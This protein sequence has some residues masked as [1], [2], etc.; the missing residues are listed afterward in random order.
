MSTTIDNRVVEMRFDNKHFENNVQ[1]SLSTIDKLKRS[2]NF[3]GA[4][5]GLENINSA[6][7][8]FDMSGMGS[9]VD[10]VKLKFS[11]LEVMAVTTLANITNSAVNAGK[12]IVSALTIDPI[13]TGFQE[14]ETQIGAVQTILA[15]TQ[16]KG[17]NL[18]DVNGAL[19]EL[20][21]YA[22]KTIYNFTEMTRNI[23]TF[24][25]AGVDLD[26][27]VSS[28][29]GI[30]NLAAVSGSTSQQASTAM[31]QLSQ[32]LA[33][34]KVQLM[35]WNSVVNAGMGGQVFQDALKRTAEH[36]GTNV[37]A[38]IEKYGSFRESLTQG[39]WLTAEVLTETLTQLSGAYS[40]ADLIAQGYTEKQAQEITEL[41]QTAVDAATKVKT[42]TQLWDTLKEAAQSGW[43]QTWEILIGDF[44]E[45]KSLWTTVSDTI[46]GLINKTS[47]SRNNLLEGAMTSNWDKLI[48]KVKDA[49]MSTEDF[50]KKVKNVAKSHDVDIDKMVEKYGSLEKVFRSGAVSSDILKEALGGTNEA[51]TTTTKEAVNHTV[52]A[53]ETLSGLAK[54][55]GT[56]VEAIAKL[57]NIKDVNLIRTGQVLKI[58]EAMTETKESTEG[59]VESIDELID[60]VTELGGRELL[61]ESFKN[62]FKTLGEV[63]KI[64][65]GTFRSIFPPTTSDQLYSMI[66]KFKELTDKFKL[67]EETSSKLR[68]TFKGLFAVLDILKKVVGGAL[69]VGFKVLAK[70]LGF[71]ADKALDVTSKIGAAA[72]R[73]RH[74]L[75]ENNRLVDGFEFTIAVFKKVAKVIK[76]VVKTFLEIPEVE[77]AIN[78]IKM[79]ISDMFSGVKDR[80]SGGVDLV[81]DFVT[82]LMTMDSISFDDVL[83]LFE[84]FKNRIIEYFSGI[85]VSSHVD[86]IKDSLGTFKDAALKYLGIAGEKFEWIKEKLAVFVD[87][88]KSKIPA[89][90][91]IGMGVGLIKGV[92]KLGKALETLASPLEGLSDLFDKVG[93][94]ISNFMKAKA[95][96]ERTEGIKNIAISI[97]IL[98]ASLTVLTM[99]DQGKLWSAVGALGVLTIAMGALAVVANKFGGLGDFGKSSLSI[100]ALTGSLFI[101]TKCIES[102]SE[103]DGGDALK[104]LGI[105]GA[106]TI[107]LAGVV[108]A[109]SKFAPKLSTGSL[110]FISLAAGIAIMVNALK[111]LDGMELDNAGQSILILLGIVGTLGLLAKACSG[112]KF[113]SLA[114]IVAMAIGLKL[115]IGVIEDIAELDVNGIKNNLESFIVIFGSLALLMVASK[116]AG[117]HAGS[118]GLGILAM[119]AAL[120]LIV[121]G[122]KGLSDIDKATLSRASNVLAKM[123]IVFAA[124]VSITKFAG[125]H[126]A[127]AGVTMLAMSSA[128]L[129]LTGAI[130]ILK[131]MDADGLDRALDAIGKI[132]LMFALLIASTKLAN[133]CVG[134]LVILTVAMGILSVAIAGLSQIE[135]D[136]LKNATTA[137]G[138]VIGM[139]ALLMGATKLISG[140]M[141]TLIVMTGAITILAGLIFLLSKLPIESTIGIAASLSMLILSLSGACAILTLI[142]PAGALSGVGALAIFIAGLGTIMAAIAGLNKL[143]PGMNEFLESGLPTIELLGKGLGSFF[144]GIVGGFAEGVTSS[145]PQ[146]ATDLSNFMTNLKPFIDG[147]KTVDASMMEGVN[148]IIDVI[149]GLTAANLIEGIASWIT[150]DSSVSTFASELPLLGEGLKAFSDNVIGIDTEAIKAAADATTTLSSMASAIP[151]EGGLLGFF[152]GENSMATFGAE[153]GLFGQGLKSFAT[154]VAGMDTEAVTAA[155]NAAMVLANMASAI[156]NEGGLV[157]WFAGEND[158]ATFGTQL[159]LFGEGLKGFAD[160][161]AGIDATSVTAAAT[162]AKDIAAMASTIPNEGG[163]LSWFAGENSMSMFATQLPLFGEGLKGFADKVAGIDTSSITSAV[164]AANSLVTM[165]DSIPNEGGLLALFAGDNDMTTFSSQ[166]PLFAEGIKGFA[167]K[168]AGIDTAAVNTAVTA[169]ADLTTMANNLPESGGLWSVFSADNDLS[170][171]SKELKKFGEG[172]S[173]FSEEVSGID[174]TAVGTSIA[175]VTRISNLATKIPEGGYEVLETF[176]EQLDGLGGDF[177]NFAADF[178]SIDVGTL[179]SAVSGFTGLV[180]VLSSVA[181]TD[182]SSLSTFGTALGDIGKDGV[183]KFIKAFTDAK[184]TVVKTGSDMIKNLIKGMEGTKYSL[185]SACKTLADSGVTA[186]KSKYSSFKSAGGYLVDGFAAG[187]SENAWKAEAKAAAMAKAALSAAEAELGVE[188]PS[189]EFYKVGRFSVIGFTNALV[190]YS[191]KAYNS[192]ASMASYAKRG[193]SDAIARV[194]DIV[195]NG[196]DTQP[197]IRPVVDLSNVKNSANAINGMLT[198]QPSLAALSNVSAI[199]L[200]MNR[201]QNGTNSDVISAIKDLGKKMGNTTNN[202]SVNGVSY[203][204]GSDVGNAIET[205]VRAVTVERRT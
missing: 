180:N 146:I 125:K 75:F 60:G 149:K 86:N 103:I 184:E 182:F 15:N 61:I 114:G 134:T 80:F 54:K 79:A 111:K 87:F 204:D 21:T 128:I 176:G 203:N 76:N 50:E 4:S 24:T 13:K 162:A 137:L 18:D 179:N 165:A 148:T 139:F 201:R 202:Y 37:D 126:A 105:L 35:D 3:K 118:A 144:G 123:L 70:V 16:S 48:Q 59:A 171:F 200:M 107:G 143:M 71:V 83:S 56:T 6:T 164:N 154:N 9:A 131:N 108:G 77:Q 89:A 63:G 136:G 199:N 28:I 38:M 84:D 167:D 106:M 163:I 74:W 46:G 195:E 117:K 138:S 159:P 68:L 57:N 141:G 101:L 177:G 53:G 183:D 170:T 82:R 142:N 109:L 30:A 122:I 169:A 91:A 8:K 2:L 98:A 113:G 11:A 153:L 1:T 175:A 45:A 181:G 129:I 85:D 39:E 47:E 133:N 14:Y 43:T 44:E 25:A 156:P 12:R 190:D 10:G 95:F 172:I 65:K 115:M 157:S 161:V 155:A 189:K 119:S 127:G 150:G 120:L 29:K 205:L 7:K 58:S 66:E 96:K 33:A 166:L 69:G 72:V 135:P 194:S 188:S 193:L 191:Y 112:I 99:L 42:F 19:D 151:N 104:A 34:G 185:I 140:S 81:K 73:F 31:Y 36:L 94:S 158:M 22:D 62:V 174:T 49:G 17:T 64:V 102:L 97:G 67:S 51:I 92:S 132:S 93:K 124:V 198:M 32:A 160:K 41:A 100:L 20:N 173:D 26:K 186:L 23:G 145:F 147:A 121:Q 90:I 197:T 168:V 152:A 130:A 192:G 52:K 116:Y 196:I 40:K 178:T 187:I 88:V 27:S 110:T 5:K 55:Y 78:K